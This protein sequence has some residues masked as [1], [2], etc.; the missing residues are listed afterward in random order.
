MPPLILQPLLEN[1]LKHGVLLEKKE[2]GFIGINITTASPNE[3]IIH[4]QNKGLTKAFKR[5]TGTTSGQKM[6]IDRI[7]LFNKRFKKTYNISFSTSFEDTYYNC[8]ILISKL[9]SN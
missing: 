1:A 4:V 8:F 9:N 3:I 6:V 2:I 7:E 5:N